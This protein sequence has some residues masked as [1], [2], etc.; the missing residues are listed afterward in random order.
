MKSFALLAMV[1]GLAGHVSS[2]YPFCQ[3]QFAPTP[4]HCAKF[5]FEKH[6]PCIES[7]NCTTFYDISHLPDQAISA[8]AAKM[9]QLITNVFE[10]GNTIMGYA[11]VVNLKDNRGYTSG[12]IGFTS[13]TNDAYTV[14]QEY[15]KRTNKNALSK[16]TAELSRLS[17][18]PFC[19]STRASISKLGQPYVDAWVES[20]CTDS[21]FVQTQL[22]LGHAMYLRPALK[23]AA[24]SGVTSNVGKAIFYGLYRRQMILLKNSTVDIFY[25]II[26]HGWQYVEPKINIWRILQLT[27]PRGKDSEQAYLLRFLNMRR[28]L[29]CCVPDN[30]S[31]SSAD[32]VSDLTDLIATSASWERNKDLSNPVR[33]A[34]Y[35]ATVKGS[36]NMGYDTK[37]CKKYKQP[38]NW[39]FPKAVDLPIPGTESCHR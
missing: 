22:D 36:E 20:A 9:A 5:G 31:P 6:P 29:L 11:Y 10:N 33:L 34:Q 37:N 23:F 28:S 24:Y 32:R 14:V 13:G 21:V 3:G 12:Y 25:T 26:E 7:T 1:L 19:N 38:K 18:L 39:H 17:N 8:Q 15:N 27:G 4:Q 16:F 35:G 2:G 30:V